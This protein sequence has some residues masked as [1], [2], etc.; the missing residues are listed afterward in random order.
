MPIF[1]NVPNVPGV[2]ALPRAAGAVVGIA[3]LLIEDAFGAFFAGTGAPQ[4]G[5]FKGGAPVVLAD[6]VL[7][8]DYKQD[9]QILTYPVEQGG[10]E[11]YNKVQIPF[12]IRL[13]F[14]TGGS[15]A[16]RE[17]YLA[18]IADAAASLDLFD[19]VSPEAIYTNVNIV[20]QDYNRRASNVGII[21]VDV[22]CQEVRVT[23][24]AAFGNTDQTANANGTSTT[25]MTVRKIGGVPIDQ[26]KSASAAPRVN[27]GVV[28]SQPP[29]TAFSD[30]LTGFM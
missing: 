14:A 1:P 5:L 7:T 11:S 13:R 18:S 22:W 30:P 27:D 29:S 26:P 12:N 10:F 8:L 17:A 15:E 3:T 24:A 25:Q 2:P 4:W 20:H 9:W 28:Q 6:T 16:D 19:V 21:A 23:S